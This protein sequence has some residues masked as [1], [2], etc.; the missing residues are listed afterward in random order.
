MRKTIFWLV[1]HKAQLLINSAIDTGIAPGF[2]VQAIENNL[3]LWD[4]APKHGEVI[5]SQKD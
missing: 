2:L 5:P 1:D 4:V 3:A